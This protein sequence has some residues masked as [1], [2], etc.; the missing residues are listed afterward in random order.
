MS[1]IPQARQ[2]R[3]SLRR[4]KAGGERFLGG[5]LPGATARRLQTRAFADDW[6]AAN[7]D[8][9]QAH[10][11]LWI[12]LGDSASQGVGATTRE[13]GYVGVVHELLR[14]RDAWRVVNLSRAGA[15]VADVLARQLP[16]LAALTAEEPAALVTCVIGAE[17]VARRTPGL[18]I[19]LRSMLAALP[20]GAVVATVPLRGPAADAAN[21]V[22]REEVVR[23]GLRVA[24]LGFTG[25]GPGRGREAVRLN[26]VGHATWSRAV[27]AAVDNP[28]PSQEVTPP[29]GIPVT[30]PAQPADDAHEPTASA[31]G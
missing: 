9:K 13:A 26:D 22:I 17:D 6:A 24:D 12:V 5:V 10:G 25:G 15:G 11:P 23:H 14:R 19:T 29:H 27:M 21:A 30:P 3:A 16:E 8:A 2:M 7:I 31:E 20:R 28:A 1:S 4:V 18:D